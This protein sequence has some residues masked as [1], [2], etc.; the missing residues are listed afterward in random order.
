M[1]TTFIV[2]PLFNLLVLIY[3]II[4]GHNFGIA[5]VVFTILIRI[6][7]WP[8]LKKQ[9]HQAK[10][11]RK[12]QPEIKKIK[13]ATKG[14]R[15]KET[16]LTMEL[17][18]E[19][20]INPVATLPIFIVQIIVLIGLYSGIERVIS[21]PKN[22]VSF[23]YSSIQHLSYIK[24]LSTNIHHFDNTLFGVVN[25]SKAAISNA[26]VYWPA[27]VIVV[28]SVIVQYYQSKQLLPTSKDQKG[29]REI[30]KQ[31]GQ[32]KQAD[33]S[34]VSAAVGKSTR[35]ILPVMIFLFTV[36]LAAD[37]SLYWLASGL[38]ALI[39]QSIALREDE[40]E[41]EKIADGNKKDLKKIPE[42]E[43]VETDEQKKSPKK[44]TKNNPK[45]KRRKK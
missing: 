28:L 44:N 30:L 22:I 6:I 20:G 18:K 39:Q 26:G 43:V 7:L 29:L 41:I 9:L 10:V 4:P 45:N 3:A 2:K 35:Y 14:D 27:M 25:L 17:Y 23:S 21:N 32:G 24:Y 36:N 1:F 16:Q 31:A 15:Q 5:L 42:A 8:L 33:Q 37:L 19:Q 12:I 38:I 40:E 34:E 11:M 13:A